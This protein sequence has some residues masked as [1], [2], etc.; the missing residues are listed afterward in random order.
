MSSY[1]ARFQEAIERTARI[2]A[3]APTVAYT[4]DLY[5][6]QNAQEMFSDHIRNTMGE[7]SSEDVVAQCLTLHLRSQAPLKALLGCDVLYTIGWVQYE[8]GKNMFEFNEEF[9]LQLMQKKHRISEQI[10]MHAWLTLPSME[11]IDMSIATSIGYFQK[12]PE[13]YGSVIA[14]HADELTGGMAY[15]PMIV[16]EDYLFKSGLAQFRHE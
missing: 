3:T 12:R 6:T 11:I 15:R 5:L 16:G 9:A 4:E 1:K 8:T 13:M 10:K 14:K 2:G 7:L